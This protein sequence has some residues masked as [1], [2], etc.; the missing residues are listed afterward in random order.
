MKSYWIESIEKNKKDFSKLQEDITVDVCIIG[1]GLTGLT[2]A[3]YLKDTNL[4]T[5]VLEK[6]KLCEHTTRKFYS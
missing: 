2:T 6:Y 3:Y 4:K 1:G 5:V